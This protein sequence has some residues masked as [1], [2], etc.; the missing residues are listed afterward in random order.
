MKGSAD[1]ADDFPWPSC[2]PERVR[3]LVGT[4][5]PSWVAL[6]LQLLSGCCGPTSSLPHES[7]GRATTGF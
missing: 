6:R 5:Q 7:S 3:T 2:E 1:E 4:I